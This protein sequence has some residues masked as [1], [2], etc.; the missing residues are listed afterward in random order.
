MVA[1]RW[2]GE[3]EIHWENYIPHD[4]RVVARSPSDETD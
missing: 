2:S 1:Y 4:P 3:P